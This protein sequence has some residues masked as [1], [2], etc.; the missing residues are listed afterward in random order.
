MDAAVR[1]KMF[2]E[3]LR[4]YVVSTLHCL[5]KWKIFAGIDVRKAPPCCVILFPLQPDVLFCGFAGVLAIKKAGAPAGF[6][7]VHKLIRRFQA[8]RKKNIQLLLTGTVTSRHYLDGAKGLEEMGETILRLKED[9]PFQNIFFQPG[10]TVELSDLVKD[11]KDFFSKEEKLLEENAGSFSTGDMET[12][13]SRHILIKDIIWSIKKDILENIGKIVQLSGSD[14][15]SALTPEK[16]KKYKKL[17]FLL[18]N[19]DRLEVRGRD[20]A[21]IQISFT[22][23]DDES[24]KSTMKI[25]QEKG[26]YDDF[27][28]RVCPGDLINGSVLLSLSPR[29][30]KH[31][32]SFVYKISSIIGELGQNVRALRKAIAGDGVFQE[33]SRIET[34]FQMSIGHT[35]WASVGSITDEN[36][37]PVNNYTVSGNTTKNYPH[38]GEGDWFISVVL[39]GD[40]DNYQ[41][42]RNDLEN[43]GAFIAPDITTDTKIIPLQIEK[44]LCEGHDLTEAFRLAVSD[45]EGSHAV[46]M[47]SNTEPGKAF[48]ALKGSGQSI[49][50]GLT[51]DQF[52]FASELYGIVEATP[53]FLKMDGEKPS[54]RN[55]FGKSEGSEAH[56]SNTGQIFVIDENSPG[57]VSGITALFYDGTPVTIG[58]NDIHRAEITTRD[59]DRGNY[60]HFFMKEIHESTLSVRKTLRGKYRISVN[61][62]GRYAV[63]FNLGHDIIPKKF[64]QSLMRGKIRRILVIGHGTAAVAGM[65][66]AD[67][68]NRYLKDSRIRIEAKV[69]SELSGFSL[70]DDL[71]D[72]LVVP[73]TQSGT[74]TD[75]NRAV[76][77][78]AERGATVIAIVNRRQSDI[79]S[80]ANGVFYT[81]DGRDIEMSVASTKAFYSQIIAGYILALCIARMLKTVSD[82]FIAGELHNL[83]QAPRMM[84]RLLEKQ[85]G[86]RQSAEQLARQRRYWAVV[87]SG[88]N[89][90][91]ADEIRI[92]SSELCYKTLSSDIIENKKHIDLSAEPLIIV[93]A[94]GNPEAVIS[95]IVKDV[96]IFKAHKSGVIVFADEG[97]ERFNKFADAV[98]EI[99]V[100]PMPLP[101]ILNTLAG[102]LW[103]YYAAC[104]IDGDA[105][106][107]RAFRSHLNRK[108]VE[109]DKKK[110][111]LYERIADRRFRRMVGDFSIKFHQ[112][113]IHD[114]FSPAAVK[115]VS[116]MLLLL[117]YASGKLPLED[118]W[119]DFKMENGFTSPIDLLDI[120]LGH[121]IDELSRP[122]DAIRHQAKTVTVGTSRKE[123]PLRGIV[124]DLFRELEFSVKSLI[125]KNILTLARINPAISGIRGYTV[126]DIG[127]LDAYGNP[128]EDSTISIERRGGISLSMTSRT[129]DSSLLMGTKRSIVSTDHVYVGRGKLDGASIV[130]IPL[131]GDRAGVG[132]LFLIHVEFN[133]SLSVK[134]KKA[135]LGYQFNDI[136]NLITEYNLPWDDRYLEAIPTGVLLGEPPEFIAGQIKKFLGKHSH[137]P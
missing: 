109:H 128:V 27:Q 111:S 67:G 56:P 91:A 78:S 116:D 86:I 35:R 124:F 45:F 6:D 55:I 1:T 24:L 29:D 135:V 32:L 7:P 129:E 4:T 23:R 30:G 43:K 114:A 123:Q 131:L 50:V 53:L 47:V 99:P 82:D 42:L 74:T 2:A 13:N 137:Q 33:F 61:E 68:F 22:L 73:I 127:H 49:Y 28:R 10:K 69:A 51:P 19:I 70:E 87:G 115:T 88:P 5:R 96:A 117:K 118:F 83:E 17:N 71:K 48:L 15:T 84:E 134:E 95:D 41:N 20:S 52:V 80:K 66:V 103:S 92:K 21:G 38:Y 100:A 62:A 130:I 60:P 85:D 8:I 101:V 65:A 36:S 132:K 57:G 136:R 110:Y 75:T 34:V 104:S 119:H 120:S 121:A 107:L 90:A 125:T 105:S 63:A 58:T 3:L 64:R 44:Y 77:M 122:I 106:I 59:I 97:E 46:A 39:N 40:V 81:S 108:M 79:T 89:K 14:R 37:H 126:Y 93:C 18:N 54:G 25:L 133:D 31:T 98:I 26:L 113:M 9:K 11:M 102:H 94:A 112:H 16:L 76:A 12:I 72:T